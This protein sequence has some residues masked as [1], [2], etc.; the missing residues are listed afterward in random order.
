[1]PGRK[2]KRKEKKTG[3]RGGEEG[4]WGN[5]GGERAGEY[6]ARLRLSDREQ[7]RI[8][9]PHMFSQERGRLV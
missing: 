5:Y 9:Y 6:K 3:E 7:Y 4:G 2:Q 1:M 8:E